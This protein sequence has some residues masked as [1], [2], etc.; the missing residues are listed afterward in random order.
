MIRTTNTRR[1]SPPSPHIIFGFDHTRIS[2]LGTKRFLDWTVDGAS[3]SGNLITTSAWNEAMQIHEVWSC[4][5]S[6]IKAIPLLWPI[7]LFVSLW[8]T[9]FL[10]ET[11]KKP[12][13]FFK[14]QFLLNRSSNAIH[15]SLRVGLTYFQHSKHRKA[16]HWSPCCEI[17]IKPMNILKFLF[18]CMMKWTFISVLL[19]CL[20]KNLKWTAN[21]RGHKW[22]K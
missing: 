11:K 6:F 8:L 14:R 17:T 18:H 13:D 21:L 9:W 22:P 7:A 1:T 16:K 2:G 4:T 15:P 3:S 5:K 20:L 19:W 10:K 12:T